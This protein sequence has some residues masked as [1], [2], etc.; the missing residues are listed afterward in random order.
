LPA[1]SNCQLLL[2]R[3]AHLGSRSWVLIDAGLAFSDG[4]IV[5]AAVV[6]THGH[7]DH[8]GALPQLADYWD[9]PIYAHEL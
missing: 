1:A 8:V 9:V 4:R 5:H 6:L 7:F 3:G 2:L